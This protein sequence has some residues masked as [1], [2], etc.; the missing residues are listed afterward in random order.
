MFSPVLIVV[1]VGELVQRVQPASLPAR[2][3]SSPG[4]LAALGPPAWRLQH[5][6]LQGM[7]EPAE[8]KERAFGFQLPALAA[9]THFRATFVKVKVFIGKSQA[10]LREIYLSSKS[11]P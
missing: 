2:H 3:Y 5:A 8:N 1:S 4:D 10:L 6:L 7:A 9:Q 11:Y